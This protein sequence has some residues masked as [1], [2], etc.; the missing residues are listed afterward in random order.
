MK[1]L[2]I[3]GGIIGI[4]GICIPSIPVIFVIIGA[5]LLGTGLALRN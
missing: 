2:I 4:L 5:A 3:C 1:V